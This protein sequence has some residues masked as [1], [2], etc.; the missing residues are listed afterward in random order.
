MLEVWLGTPSPAC[1]IGDLG[2]TALTEGTAMGAELAWG[3][4]GGVG[5]GLWCG[6]FGLDPPGK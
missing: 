6:V 5:V 1:P 3:G 2:I 4:A